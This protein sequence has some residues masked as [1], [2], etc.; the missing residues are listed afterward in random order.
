MT[1]GPQVNVKPSTR[2]F[3][4]KILSES[5]LYPWTLKKAAKIMRCTIHSSSCV[6]L[7]IEKKNETHILEHLSDWTR[8]PKY[9]WSITYISIFHQIKR[10]FDGPWSSAGLVESKKRANK[11]RARPKGTWLAWKW[12]STTKDKR[13]LHIACQNFS[14]WFQA[15]RK[16]T[17]YN[18]RDKRISI[19]YITEEHKVRSKAIWKSSN[20]GEVD[21]PAGRQHQMLA[22][23][24]N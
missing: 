7:T 18:M 8:Y 17:M 9:E 22:V 21:Y 10:T 1:V 14:L 12:E 3:Y 2:L 20:P 13:T 19:N 6:I 11:T 4:R 15:Y 23:M 24:G 16:Q 5:K